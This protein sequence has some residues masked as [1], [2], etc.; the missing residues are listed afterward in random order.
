MKPRI[1]YIVCSTARTGS[2]LLCLG[3]QRT[4]VCGIPEEYF[5]PSTAFKIQDKSLGLAAY[6]AYL[7]EVLVKG[8]TPNGVFGLKIHWAN[9]L[10]FL[11]R[12]KRM[13][14]YKG[15]A[16]SVILNKIF[17]GVRYLYIRR[18]DIVRQAVSLEK[19]FQT[20]VWT[21]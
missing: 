15:T 13:D 20:N 10:G 4:G 16:I 8:A 18:R 2:T 21:I 12:I 3:L 1:S 7:D 11:A 17:P 14:R 6:G 9:W 19:A 5:N